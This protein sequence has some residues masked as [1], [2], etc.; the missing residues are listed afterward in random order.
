MLNQWTIE[1]INTI[2]N[3]NII[4]VIILAIIAIELGYIIYK[5]YIK[6]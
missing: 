1:R 5:K 2:K 6:K 4:I 3:T